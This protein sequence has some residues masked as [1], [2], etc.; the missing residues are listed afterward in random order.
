MVAAGGDNLGL[1]PG[2]GQSFYGIY[3]LLLRICPDV[4]QVPFGV[5]GT[6]RP[7]VDRSGAGLPRAGQ[8]PER[9][10]HEKG[11]FYQGVDCFRTDRRLLPALLV[12]PVC[13]RFF[14]DRSR[15]RTTRYPA[16]GLAGRPQRLA[17][18]GC[19]PFLLLHRLDLRF[20]AVGRISWSQARFHEWPGWP[21]LQPERLRHSCHHSPFRHFRIGARRFV[22]R[23]ETLS[24]RR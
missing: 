15:T 4:F 1:V 23:G 8:N 3:P 9:G 14:P 21:R 7:A 20:V 5:D 18:G 12:V 16:G 19:P 24:F 6:D 22:Q 2:L 11:I 13:R 17:G 10:V